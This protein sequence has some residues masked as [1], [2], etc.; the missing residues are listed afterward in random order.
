MIL[1]QYLPQIIRFAEESEDME[2]VFII[3]L[4]VID[5]MDGYNEGKLVK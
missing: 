4:T 1:T 2:I 5:L 3:L